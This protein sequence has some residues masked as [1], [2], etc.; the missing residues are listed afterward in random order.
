MTR[1]SRKYQNRFWSYSSVTMSYL[2]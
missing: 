1:K 2:L